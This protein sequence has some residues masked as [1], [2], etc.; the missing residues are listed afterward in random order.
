[1]V[2][3]IAV[4]WAKALALPYCTAKFLVRRAHADMCCQLQRKDGVGTAPH[5]LLAWQ[6]GARA[7]A[8]PT[9]L[10]TPLPTT[11]GRCDR[12]PLARAQIRDAG[13]S[14]WWTPVRRVP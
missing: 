14:S 13:R 11:G 8:H 9:V 2:A 6:G 12:V 10:C 5:R 1:M 4:V 7:F 3:T